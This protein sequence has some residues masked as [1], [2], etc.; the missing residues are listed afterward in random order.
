MSE[1]A[2]KKERKSSSLPLWKKLVF[3]VFSLALFFGLIELVLVFAGVQPLIYE[4][5]PYLGFSS[6]VPLYVGK[7]GR[8]G[9]V[10]TARNKLRFFNQQEFSIEKP[11]GTTRIFCLGGSTTYGRPYDDTTSFCGWLRELLPKV[12]SSRKWEVIN[13]G[14]ISYASYRIAALVEELVEYEPDILIVYCG[15]NEFL[16]QRTYAGI[17]EM[18]ESLRGLGAVLSHTR[19]YSGLARIIRGFGKKKE[20][21]ADVIDG[22]VNAI[23]DQAVGLDAYERDDELARQVLDHYRFN[24]ARIADIARAHGAEVLFVTPASNL[25][26]CS[27]FKSQHRDGLSEEERTRWEALA[28]KGRES[29]SAGEYSNAIEALDELVGLDDRH[30][31]A[32]Y[33]RARALEGL[34]RYDE[35][36][37]AFQRALEEDVCPLRALSAVPKILKEVADDRQVPLVDFEKMVNEKS[38][39]GIPGA[40]LFLDHV[41][42]TIDGHRMLAVG[43]VEEMGRQGW[44]EGDDGLDEALVDAVS[45][46]VMSKVDPKKQGEAMR[47]LS[48]VY[49]WAGK[50]EDAYQAARKALELFPGDAETNYQVGNLARILGKKEEAIERLT[51]LCSA[52]LSPKVSYYV[53]AHLQ[54]SDLLSTEGRFDESE[55]LLRKLMQLDPV[56]QAAREQL[57]RLVSIH[58]NKLMTAGDPAGAASRFKTLSQLQPDN[59]EVRVKLGVALVRTGDYQAA[60]VLLRDLIKRRPG[61]LPAYDNLSFVLAQLGKVEEA[62]QV[63]LEALRIDPSHEAAKKNLRLIRKM[64]APQ[65]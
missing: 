20:E 30:A 46:K 32:H 58:G 38:A 11:S 40:G 29:L 17:I 42:P 55:Q 56:N 16:E 12:D 43:L 34:K 31:E 28:D 39:N 64:K 19:T 54:L 9:V 23:L 35:A 51:Y 26:N 62:E 33:L 48:K 22:E 6:Q 7:E 52:N 8:E 41:H 37:V 50:M 4:D 25:G 1:R 57:A 53:K 60:S 14:G 45:K 65:N 5:D 49:S 61:F 59:F 47:N 24:M 21:E 2:E 3:S 36:K 18:P 15:Q 44:V 27:P 10:T 13:A 63:C